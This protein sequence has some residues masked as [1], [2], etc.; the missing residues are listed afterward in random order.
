MGRSI[1]GSIRPGDRV[2]IVDDVVTTGTSTLDAIDRCREAGHAITAVVLLVDRQEGG[3]DRIR[4]AVPGVPCTALFGVAEL[5]ER[6]LAR[7]AGT[8]GR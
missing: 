4:G 7:R 6:V 5:K 8:P 1:E 3:L 2:A